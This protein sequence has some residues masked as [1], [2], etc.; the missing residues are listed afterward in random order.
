MS[1]HT[2]L[3]INIATTYNLFDLGALRL[4]SKYIGTIALF[5]QLD[6]FF[7]LSDITG[8]TV[9]VDYLSFIRSDFNRQYILP[10]G[11]VA[12]ITDDNLDGIGSYNGTSGSFFF[13]AIASVGQPIV[14]T[15][16]YNHRFYFNASGTDDT[17][18]RDSGASAK[19]YYRPRRLTF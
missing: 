5:N 12:A 16:G 15:P 4:P 17:Q 13:G 6:M 8:I 11:G 9:K 18:L 7:F 19:L 2:W 14:L 10:T 1:P 3:D